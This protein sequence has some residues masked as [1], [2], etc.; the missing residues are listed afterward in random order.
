MVNDL[1]LITWP[2]N[3]ELIVK[4]LRFSFKS[5]QKEVDNVWKNLKPD[6]NFEFTFT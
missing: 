1:S 2:V 5:I 3:V 6:V 4:N